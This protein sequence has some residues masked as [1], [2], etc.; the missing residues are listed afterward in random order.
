MFEVL[1]PSLKTALGFSL[2]STPKY[3]QAAPDSAPTLVLLYMDAPVPVSNN[4]SP[5][6]AHK[7]VA[8]KG[9]LIICRRTSKKDHNMIDADWIFQLEQILSRRHYLQIGLHL[10]NG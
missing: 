3:F 10:Y 9:L 5:I 1:E 6:H 4:T 8:T 7:A 2:V